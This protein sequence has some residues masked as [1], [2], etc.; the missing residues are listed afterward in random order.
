MP[1]G[2]I[3]NI[4][5]ARLTDI[6]W[7]SDGSILIVSSV[8]GFCTVITFE[9]DELGIKY[10]KPIII[11]ND[12]DDKANL[13]KK[14]TKSKISPTQN[15]EKNMSNDS[16]ETLKSSKVESN[17]KQ[18]KADDIIVEIPETI[19]ATTETFE[20][21]GYKTKRATPIA[22]RRE[23]RTNVTPNTNEK[24][25]TVQAPNSDQKP[26]LIAIRRQPRKILPSSTVTSNKS[27]AN[28]DEEEALDAWPI[29]IDSL[30]KTE[31]NDKTVAK[32]IKIKNTLQELC[33]DKTEDMRLIYEGESEATLIR[34]LINDDNDK[35]K[36]TNASDN[37]K[38]ELPPNESVNKE[39]TANTPDSKNQ[40][41]PR[42]V[43]L[44]TI[45]TPKSKKKLIN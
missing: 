41:T 10:T 38:C 13:S 43:Q 12:A 36:Q 42:R 18:T 26:K 32:D 31:A 27:T 19:I 16:N 11:M 5:Y 17:G 1:F 8:D 24:S 6:T 22:I 23:P 14:R 20:S 9:E 21:S 34:P 28:Q 39:L 4:H 7:S 30:L 2:C 44:R 35:V 37:S 25:T 45:S 15:K 40:K 3:S 33:V 29:P